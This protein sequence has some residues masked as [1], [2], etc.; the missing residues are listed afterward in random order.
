M[1][2]G[3][4]RRRLLIFTAVS[5]LVTLVAAGSALVIVFENHLLKRVEQELEIRWTELAK[6]FELDGAGTPMLNHD[7][8]D[9]R[10]LQPYGQAYWQVGE[11][12]QPVLRSRSLWDFV[13]ETREAAAKSKSGRAFEV[14]GPNNSELYVIARDV[15]LQ[16][17]NGVR[18]FS[19]V[20]GLDH[21]D[22]NEL[23]QAFAW[24]VAKLLTLL[25]LLLVGGAWLQLRV[26]LRPLTGLR[27]ALAAVRDGRQ[28]RLTGRFPDEVRPLV[29]DLN[30]LL[31]RQEALV[32]K[33][34]GRAGS[35][36][37]GLKTP[38]T[39][40][41]G[42]IARLERSGRRESTAEL[43][44]QCNAIRAHVE[45]ELAKARTHGASAVQMSRTPVL[46]VVTKLV[47]MMCRLDEHNRLSWNIMVPED[48]KASME[49][50]DFTEVAG[51]LIDNARKWADTA[52]TIEITK[53]AGRTLFSIE[54]D[55]P[56][57]PQH[58][59]DDILLRGVHFGREGDE[60]SGLGLAIVR[61]TLAQYGHE[62]IISERGRGFRISFDIGPI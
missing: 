31:D 41:F 26:G 14:T 8:A 17:Q 38:L 49:S 56:G 52:V 57:V 29:D 21:D 15:A 46:P 60:S 47:N 12:D 54:D 34:R 48:V 59:R 28:Q 22:V 42:E 2:A 16:G 11:A 13:M 1:N 35:L 53:S 20:V 43:R 5:M 4:L 62:P 33:A 18:N 61:D 7:L 6:A 23:R 25:L 19:L 10:Y 50:A 24:D 58:L 44:Q 40:L 9:P 39:I 27:G 37:H 36:A 30:A 32:E 51:N 45:R 55:G 3:S